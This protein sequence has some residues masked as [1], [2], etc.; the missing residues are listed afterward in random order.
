MKMRVRLLPLVIAVAVIT[1]GFRLEAL[2]EGVTAVAQEAP[3]TAVPIDP[4]PSATEPAAESSEA[5]ADGLP[6][7]DAEGAAQVETSTLLS[8]L[9]TDPFALTDSEIELLQALSERRAELDRREA[10][11]ETREALLTAAETR[12]EQKIAE[13]EELQEAYA[14]D[15]VAMFGL[16][17]ASGDSFVSEYGV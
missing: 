16:E 8:A 12:I 14:G 1:L 5:S 15:I 13:L 2:R 4:F 7:A 17:C 3:P 9:P 11:F 10:E 6:A